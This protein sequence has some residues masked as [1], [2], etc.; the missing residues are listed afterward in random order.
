MC[1]YIPV[2]EMSRKWKA[3]FTV[4]QKLELKLKYPNKEYSL[5][6]WH[7]KRK[8]KAIKQNVMFDFLLVSFYSLR[9]TLQD[10]CWTMLFTVGN[11]KSI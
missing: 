5:S 4:K 10:L 7:F 11:Q 1:V 6:T 8:A 9:H 3:E 2:M